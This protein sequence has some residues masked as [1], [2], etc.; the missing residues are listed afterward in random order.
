[1]TK[2]VVDELITTL[3]QTF[4]LNNEGRSTI[5]AIRPYIYMH[6]APSGTFTLAVKSGVTT[7]ASN[8]FTS[9]TIK[10]DLST[11]DNYTHSWKTIQFSTPLIL[12]KGEYEL[13]LSAA[14][15]TFSNSSYL[16]WIREHEHLTNTRLGTPISSLYEPRAF[17]L[18]ERK[19]VI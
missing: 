11:S 5:E 16:A 8:T 19:S 6:N 14:G 4:T 13:E 7:L 15:Y 10:S 12:D 18:M 3:S 2:L 1:M 17:Q 9:T